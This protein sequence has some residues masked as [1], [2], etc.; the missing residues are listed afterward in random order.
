MK[1]YGNILSFCFGCEPLGGTDWG[2]VY[3]PDIEEAIQE[4][5]DLGIKYFDTAAV[6]GL[7]LS[8]KRLSNI[9]GEKRHDVIIATKGGFSWRQDDQNHRSIV[10]RDSSPASIRKNIEGSLS[11]LK[12][13]C[14]PIFYIHWPDTNFSIRETFSTLMELCSEGKIDRIGCSNFNVSQLEKACAVSNVSFIQLP[15]NILNNHIDNKILSLS[16]RNNIKIVVYNV[17]ANGLLTGKYNKLST[18]PENDRRSRLSNFRGKPYLR[19][20]KQIDRLKIEAEIN[21]LTLAQYAIKCVIEVPSI[22]S[23]IL[24]IKNSRQLNENFSAVQ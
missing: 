15:Y 23:V 6:Y 9:L 10:F 7:G 1:N 17:L 16:K 21:N 2:D 12:I 20:L 3:I 8:E 22:S 19:V 13:D 5:L 24:G 14:L 11:R 18:F 4:A